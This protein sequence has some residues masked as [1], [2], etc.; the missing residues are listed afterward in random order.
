MPNSSSSW[1]LSARIT[2]VL[3]QRITSKKLLP[4]DKLPSERELCEEFGVSR[5]AVREAIGNLREK[6]L[7]VV[8]PGRGAYVIEATTETVQQS[9][10]L[11][12]QFASGADINANLTQIRA[13]LEPEIA[14]LAAVRATHEQVEALDMAIAEMD[15]ALQ[16]PDLYIEADQAFHQALAIATHNMLL[17]ALMEPIVDLL[18]EQRKN[19]F[20]TDNG[21]TR[22]QEHHKKILDAVKNREPALARSAMQSH[23]EQVREDST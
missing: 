21:P 5:S 18:Q 12:M 13:I 3:E 23:L 22:G 15:K 6:G 8:H 2:D 10:G 16:I 20:F 17:I 11:I 7:V 1:R 9:F 14:A 4:G 19:I